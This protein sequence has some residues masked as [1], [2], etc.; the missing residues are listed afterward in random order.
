VKISLSLLAQIY[1]AL[2]AKSALYEQLQQS[3]IANANDAFLV[4][5]SAKREQQPSSSSSAS[6][7]KFDFDDDDFSDTE[8]EFGRTKRIHRRSKEYA[9]ILLS[10]ELK[11]RKKNSWEGSVEESSM[12]AN[13]SDNGN[14]SS[15]WSWSKG[16]LE[17]DTSHLLSSDSK[18]VR[19]FVHHLYT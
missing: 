6:S 2:K 10:R 4:D 9:E 1:S 17:D 8:D 18:Y 15:E 12:P 3:G 13:R 5:F 16:Q 7:T 11:R 14:V 19:N